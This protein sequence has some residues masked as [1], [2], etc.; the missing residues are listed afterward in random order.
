MCVCTR[1]CARVCACVLD[2]K[3]GDGLMDLMANCLGGNERDAPTLCYIVI[4]RQGENIGRPPERALLSVSLP[5]STLL[6]TCER[7]ECCHCCHTAAC[8]NCLS[9]CVAS[10]A[11]ARATTDGCMAPVL[12]WRWIATQCWKLG[13]TVGVHLL[14]CPQ[15]NMHRTQVWP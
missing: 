13:L 15:S 3:K 4:G 10:C 14:V 5:E 7:C 11:L 12:D 8:R 2:G 9:D 1:V 6:F